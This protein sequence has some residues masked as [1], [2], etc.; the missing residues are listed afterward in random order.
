MS[1]NLQNFLYR[2]F[3]TLP[4]II[5]DSINGYKYLK[6]PAGFQELTIYYTFRE[7][8]LK[9][10]VLAKHIYHKYNFHFSFFKYDCV[11]TVIEE[12]E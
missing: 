3:A 5:S 7:P 8:F 11:K 9:I 12:I 2:T 1:E 6:D 4:R 10:A